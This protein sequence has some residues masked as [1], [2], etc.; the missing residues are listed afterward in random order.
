VLALPPA[1]A[2]TWI[3]LPAATLCLS[4]KLAMAAEASTGQQHGHLVRL[5]ACLVAH[6]KLLSDRLDQQLNW[7][8]CP[9]FWPDLR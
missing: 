5:G 4:L 1:A 9:P 8:H 2:T 6:L 3:R 7:H